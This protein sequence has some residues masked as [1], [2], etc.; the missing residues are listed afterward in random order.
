MAYNVKFLAG[1]KTAF[2]ALQSKDANTLYFV[3]AAEDKKTNSENSK[4][5]P[6]FLSS[7]SRLGN[8][9]ITHD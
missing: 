9:A 8:M 2:D 5:A 1:S 3:Q 7:K 6:L 4:A